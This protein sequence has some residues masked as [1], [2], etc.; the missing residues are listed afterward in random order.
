MFCSHCGNKCEDTDLFCS[1]CG[2]KLVKNQCVSTNNKTIMAKNENS[3]TFLRKKLSDLKAKNDNYS[4]IPNIPEK[5]LINA[6]NK[7]A[8]GTDSSKIIAVYDTTLL[9]SGKEGI[10]FTGTCIYVKEALTGTKSIPLFNLTKVD[11]EIQIEQDNSGKE[12]KKTIYNFIYSNGDSIIISNN[13]YEF[14]NIYKMLQEFVE[15]VGKI[16]EKSYRFNALSDLGDDVIY[17]YISIICGYLKSDDGIIDVEEYTELTSLMA[18]IKVAKSIAGKLRE[19]RLNVENKN[20]NLQELV[21]N[22]YNTLNKI[23]FDTKA[24]YQSLFKDLLMVKKGN[25]D[26]WKNDRALLLLQELLEISNEQINVFIKS[27]KADERIVNERLEDNQIKEITKEITAVAGGAGVTLAALAVTGGVSSGIWG[28]LFTLGF[29]ST[30]GMLLGLATIGGLGYGAYKGIKYFSGTSELEKSGIRISA[31]QNTIENN[32]RATTYIIEDINWLTNKI[33][34][35]FEKIQFSDE[36]N[37]DLTN[38]IFQ[39]LGFAESVG[40][41]GELI[42]ESTKKSSYEIHI[43]KLP[44]TLPVDRFNELVS[45]NPN[46]TEISKFIFE[47]YKKKNISHNDDETV[48][49]PVYQRDEEISYDDAEKAYNDFSIIGFFDTKTSAVA[50]GQA[51]TKKGIKSVKNILGV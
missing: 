30:G 22:L 1:E 19:S 50:Q 10:V 32:K 28:G 38:E 41:T 9:S 40:Q 24:V 33:K 34:E 36:M 5:V 14:E 37:K 7:I 31:L 16:E 8:N 17:D 6:S 15:S 26:D 47:L 3:D 45:Q 35:L 4:I 11:R 13:D 23:D 46:K 21:N 51:L 2:S 20:I 27:I 49:K 39:Y 42:E 29:M 25:I 12:I 44:L 48:S 18:R 43:A